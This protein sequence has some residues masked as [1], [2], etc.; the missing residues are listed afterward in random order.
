MFLYSVIG[1]LIPF[2]GTS[3]GSALVFFLKDKI[4]NKLNK[5]MIGFA[6]GVMLS[7]SIF[8]LLI[9]SIEMSNN[10]IIV[11]IGFILGFLFLIII[12]K[13]NFK[14]DKLILSVTIHNIPE[15]MAVGVCFAG[16]LS[17]S[18]LISLS[19][20]FALAI[21]IALQNIPEG[22]I[23][24]LP[25]KIKGSSKIKSFIY[26]VLS[27]IV[28]PIA[29]IITIVILNS[30]VKTLPYLLSFASGAMIYVIF[31]ELVYEM[32]NKNN[33]GIIG[34]L[35]GFLIMMILDIKL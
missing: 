24:S 35:I 11:S 10:A 29:S 27:G 14:S 12:N 23:I 3:I 7:S 4:N 31:D 20:S 9:P 30:V 21:G 19:A 16:Y 15:G 34:I 28:E 8:S 18:S 6:I 33:I 26:G 1:I 25:L 13:I 32:D 17:N 5:M 22:A 2:I